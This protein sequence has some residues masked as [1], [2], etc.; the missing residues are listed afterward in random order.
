MKLKIG[1]CVEVIWEDACGGRGWCAPYEEGVEVVS[2]GILVRNTKRGICL[3][4]GIDN[5]DKELEKVLLPSF[6]PRGMV[7]RVRKLR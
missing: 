5:E 1:D 4:S 7:K 3:A 2:A 6:I